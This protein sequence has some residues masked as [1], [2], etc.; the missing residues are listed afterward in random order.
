M[1]GSVSE[2]PPTGP[3]LGGKVGR[4]PVGGPQGWGPLGK[5]D[6]QGER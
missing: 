4:V 6:F 3:R 2:A 5:K 1:I